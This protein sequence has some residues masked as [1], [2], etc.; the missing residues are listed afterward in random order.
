MAALVVSC[1]NAKSKPGPTAAPS[2]TAAEQ[3]AVLQQVLDAI[4]A[5][6]TEA[7]WHH[8]STEARAT[9]THEDVARLTQASARFRFRGQIEDVEEVTTA[10]DKSEI[11]LTLG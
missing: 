3:I 6:D 11:E 9:L 1:S 5:Q 2:P 7:I 4:G 8:L 10:N